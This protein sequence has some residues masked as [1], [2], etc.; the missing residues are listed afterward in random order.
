[1]MSIE[2]GTWLASDLASGTGAAASIFAA[3][4]NC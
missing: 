4:P 2:N 3:K 1:V